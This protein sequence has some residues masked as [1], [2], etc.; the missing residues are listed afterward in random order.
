MDADRGVQ[1]EA[2]GGLPLEH[3]GHGVV[4][5]EASPLEEGE[6]A[7]LQGALQALDVGG[8]EVRRLV[9][10]DGAVH[11]LGE[12]AVQY[13]QRNLAVRSR[14]SRSSAWSWSSYSMARSHAWW[15]SG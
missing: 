10:G 14:P 5:Q 12:E 9:K 1:A 4:I 3:T 11:L 7:A 13:G 8:G 15:D 2:A 6:D